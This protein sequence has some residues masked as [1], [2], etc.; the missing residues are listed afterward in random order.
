MMYLNG[1]KKIQK[2]NKFDRSG[3]RGG[4]KMLEKAVKATKDFYL[5]KGKSE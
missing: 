4:N 2:Q 5:C 3:N 1:W